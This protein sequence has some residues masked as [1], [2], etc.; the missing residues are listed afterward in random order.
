VV[1]LGTDV[2][3]TIDVLV[4]TLDVPSGR[5]RPYSVVAR[6]LRNF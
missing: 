4:A 1:P 6:V 5:L 2:Q 3:K